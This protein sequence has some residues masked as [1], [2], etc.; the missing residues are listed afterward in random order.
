MIAMMSIK[1]VV[2]SPAIDCL[3][4]ASTVVYANRGFRETA[5]T[6]ISLL[7]LVVVIYNIR[8]LGLQPH[9]PRNGQ[10]DSL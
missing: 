4:H 9:G 3:L 10:E 2:T 6:T 7:Y 5:T 1:A 8:L